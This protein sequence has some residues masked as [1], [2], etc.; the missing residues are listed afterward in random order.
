MKQTFLVFCGAVAGGIVG[1]FAFFWIA[2]QGL[3]ALALPGALLGLGAGVVRN[4][5]L[6]VAIVCGLAATALGLLAEWRFAPFIAN[7]GLG[8]FLAHVHQLKPITLIMVIVG[9]LL[10]FWMPY[11]RTP[12]SAARD[13]THHETPDGPLN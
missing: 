9:G 3:Y 6:L 2:D 8:Y 12:V 1:Y 5:S 13:S 4:R 10:G 11:R 7:D